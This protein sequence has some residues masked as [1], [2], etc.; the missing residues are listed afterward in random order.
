MDHTKITEVIERLPDG[1]GTR[2]NDNGTV[3]SDGQKQRIS[4]SRALLN[5]PAMIIFDEATS[6][7]DVDWKRRY[8]VI[9]E[10][11]ITTPSS[12]LLPNRTTQNQVVAARV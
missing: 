9:S 10:N 8:S 5:N 3:R 12:S 2:I 11:I 6:E 7:L 4:I 1:E